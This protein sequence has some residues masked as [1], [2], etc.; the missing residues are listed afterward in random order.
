M[1]RTSKVRNTAPRGNL[2]SLVLIAIALA[3]AVVVVTLGILGSSTTEGLVIM[4]GIGLFAL[5]L[6]TLR[7]MT[8]PN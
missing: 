1:T 6:N 8:T 2:M 5:A 7:S 3:M 4:L